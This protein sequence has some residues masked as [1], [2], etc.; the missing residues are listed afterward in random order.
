MEKPLDETRPKTWLYPSTCQEPRVPCSLPVSDSSG[1][2]GQGRLGQAH[3]RPVEP[4]IRQRA[5]QASVHRQ[6]GDAWTVFKQTTR[7]FCED[8]LW[9]CSQELSPPFLPFLFPRLGPP[10][11]SLS[12]SLL[13]PRLPS[14]GATLPFILHPQTSQPSHITSMF[15]LHPH[16]CA[17][18]TCSQAH[19]TQRQAHV[20]Y[21]LAGLLMPESP[22]SSSLS[23][24]PA[25][26]LQSGLFACEGWLC[27]P[28]CI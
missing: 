12:P 27:W 17:T 24:R 1:Q 4:V 2:T 15:T 5:T 10:L 18:H 28:P 21:F 16:V 8:F 13:S 6:A 22:V 26:S 7:M 11:P 14:H 3:W 23:G 25:S 19:Y 9:P 20:P